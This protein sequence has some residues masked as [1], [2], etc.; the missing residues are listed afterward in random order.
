MTSTYYL[1]FG[2]GS[3]TVCHPSGSRTSVPQGTLLRSSILRKVIEEH[4]GE[5]EIALS[6]SEELL[7]AWLSWVLSIQGQTCPETPDLHVQQDLASKIGVLKVR[8]S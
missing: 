1:H 5:A 3:V 6:F 8:F 4:A 2:D 7:E